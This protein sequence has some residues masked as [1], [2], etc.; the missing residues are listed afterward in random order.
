MGGGASLTW[1]P[2]WSFSS[3]LKSASIRALAPASP[4]PGTG[5][6]I[7]LLEFDT[8]KATDVS[9]YVKLIG[10]PAAVL[11]NLSEV[12]VNGGAVL[13]PDEDEV[14]LDIDDVMD[15]APGAKV[16]VYDAPF[17]GPGASFQPLLAR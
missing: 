3:N 2:N 5:Q 15:I 14:L 9:N 16:I 6:S 1:P 8:F 10:Y 11:S 4:A 12:K 17:A 13:G 7:G